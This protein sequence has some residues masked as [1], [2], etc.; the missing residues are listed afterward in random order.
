MLLS[1][2]QTL[3]LVLVLSGGPGFS[4]VHEPPQAPCESLTWLARAIPERT[5][6]G[7]SSL[8][9]RVSQASCMLELTLTTPSAM[10]PSERFQMRVYLPLADVDPSRLTLVA[11]GNQTGL[12]L[13]SRP[14]RAFRVVRRDGSCA[15]V[16]CHWHSDFTDSIQ[17]LDL[18]LDDPA[19]AWRIAA[20]F[21][22]HLVAR[23]SP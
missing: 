19:V 5:R 21:R 10:Q 22:E 16:Q 7:S 12:T 6:T 8:R 11:A 2:M 3:T 1:M 20:T 4:G 17:Q 14:G 18:V 15:E 23:N 13:Y 9:A